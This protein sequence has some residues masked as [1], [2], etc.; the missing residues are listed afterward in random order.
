MEEK[1]KKRDKSYERFTVAG[2]MFVEFSACFIAFFQREKL[3][4]VKDILSIMSN[5]LV[6]FL[7]GMIIFT[8][9]FIIVMLL[10]CIKTENKFLNALI[11]ILMYTIV[12]ILFVFFLF[13]CMD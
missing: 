4:S 8:I 12:P 10:E 5:Q 2:F 3:E 11:V 1:E 13:Y 9:L 7:A 6:Y